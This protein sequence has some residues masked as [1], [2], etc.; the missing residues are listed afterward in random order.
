MIVERILGFAMTLSIPFV[1]VIGGMLMFEKPESA[2][3]P[4]EAV[5]IVERRN[6]A[7]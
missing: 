1:I 5:S 6:R 3:T 4:R 2:E 7:R